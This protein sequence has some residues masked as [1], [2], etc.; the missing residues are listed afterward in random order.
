[1]ARW[2]LI[3]GPNGERRGACVL[4]VVEALRGRGLEVGGFVQER[5]LDEKGRRR[6]RVTRLT[7]GESAA[8]MTRGVGA[9][10]PTDVRYCN[11]TF[12]PDAFERAHAWMAEDAATR[13][14]LVLAEAGSLEAAGEGHAAALRTALARED[15]VV[16]LAV[17][18]RHLFYV[19]ERFGLG[20][21]VAAVE[22]PAAS[23]A[24][25]TALVDAVAAAASL[26]SSPTGV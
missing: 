14:V 17:Q 19:M 9:R 2:A 1:M 7:T 10:R 18:P 16:V 21:P 20:A 15:V 25:W 3:G 26:G 12:D 5:D 6:Q 13:R 23:D 24:N 8:L 4:K 22:S 11:L